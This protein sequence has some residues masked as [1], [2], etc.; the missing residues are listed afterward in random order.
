MLYVT[1]S[2]IF[3]YEYALIF[4]SIVKW[5]EKNTQFLVFSSKSTSPRSCLLCEVIVSERVEL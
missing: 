1:S 5:M 4:E 3:L 2:L